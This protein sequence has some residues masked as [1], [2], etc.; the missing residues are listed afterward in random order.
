VQSEGESQG[1]LLLFKLNQS[2]YANRPL[3]LYVLNPKD[4]KLGSISLDL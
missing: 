3:T 2:A 4:Q 1:G